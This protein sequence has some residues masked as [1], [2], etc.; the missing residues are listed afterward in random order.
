MSIKECIVSR[1]TDGVIMEADYSQ[2]EVIGLA[3]ASRD[4]NLMSDIRNGIDLHCMSASFLYDVPYTTVKNAV[5]QGDPDWTAKR[6]KA[7]G[8]SFQLQYGA[9]AYSI[10][11]NC[12]ITVDE[13]K[14]FISNYYSRYPGVKAWQDNNIEKVRKS[15]QPSQ[16]RT[17][18]GLP[19]GTGELQSETGRIYR[20]IEQDAPDWSDRQTDFSPTQIKNYPVQG[21]ATGDIVPM[22]LG[23]LFDNFYGD[24]DV[25]LINTV[26]DSILFDVSDDVNHKEVARKIKTI[27]EQAPDY[28]NSRFNPKIKFDLPLKA[29]VQWG[30]S[31]GQM[32]ETL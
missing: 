9:G 28:F 18:K 29:E 12:N 26:H 23:V 21:L 1:F 27:M 25:L 10:S 5:V 11:Q 17:Q 20:F 2:L 8:P 32:T 22:M 6:K 19:A 15:R 7:K 24:P 30:K 3:Y 13:A 16:H 31:W 4:N 14:K